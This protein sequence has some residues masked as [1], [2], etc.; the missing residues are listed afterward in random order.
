MNSSDLG[1]DEFFRRLHMKLSKKS[2]VGGFLVGII[3]LLSAGLSFAAGCL[4]VLSSS[5]NP[6][7]TYPIYM[8]TTNPSSANCSSMTGHRFFIGGG[9]SGWTSL[10]WYSSTATRNNTPAAQGHCEYDS[11]GNVICM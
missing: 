4:C 2:V 5:S 7:M 10:C 1:I 6:G 8:E 11:K 9:M 3:G